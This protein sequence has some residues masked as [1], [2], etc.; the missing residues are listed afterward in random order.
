MFPYVVLTQKVD[1][2]HWANDWEREWIIKCWQGSS[3]NYFVSE[4]NRS[5]M[6]QQF[7]LSMENAEIVRNPFLTNVA[8]P[9]PWSFGESETIRLAC[10]GRLYPLDKG[11]DILLR[12]LDDKKWRERN[13]EVAFFGE[14]R[15]EAGLK[16]F[17]AFLGLKNVAFKGH[18]QDIVSIWKSHQA[19]ILPSRNEGLPLALVEAM[20]C[21]RTAIVTDV[22]GNRDVLENNVTGFI[23]NSVDEA[24]VDEALERAWQRV[25]E[26]ERIGNLA[27][28]S[29]RKNIPENPPEVFAERL[30]SVIDGSNAG[31]WKEDD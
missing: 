5:L 24:G 30:L 7:C 6:Q 11:Q 1:K 13:L 18:I 10:V 22:G 25:N 21:G 20:L 8:E 31:N 17:A 27:A 28:I 4:E 26:W 3:R 9:L 16:D 14:G 19:L 2:N 15:N 12:V 23:A 29:I